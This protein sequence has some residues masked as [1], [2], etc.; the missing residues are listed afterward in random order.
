[1][2]SNQGRGF[3]LIELM[4]VVAIVG[5]LATLAY[6]SFLEQ[7]RLSRRVDAQ[8]TLLDISARQ[9][10]MILD[11]RRYATTA[12]ALHVS[13]PRAVAQNYNIAITVGTA[14]VPSFVASATPIGTQAADR[15]GVL[16]ITEAAVKTPDTCW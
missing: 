14:A 15:C 1:M 6:P 4:I 12:A 13:I 8:A 3:T 5:I 7:I 16:R 2:F 11:T 9:Q 10:Q